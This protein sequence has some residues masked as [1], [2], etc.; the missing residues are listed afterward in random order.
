M[1]EKLIFIN[2]EKASTYE[3]DASN[4]I[5]LAF[6][7][8]KIEETSYLHYYEHGYDY[9]FMTQQGQIYLLNSLFIKNK[10]MPYVGENYTIE[11]WE[12]KTEGVIYIRNFLCKDS[13]GNVFS[14]CKTH[15]ILVDFNTHK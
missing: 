3:C 10:R 1:E 11:T 13:N 15:W 4:N 5:K 14:S 2:H 8:K 9:K 7:L 6:F 12:E